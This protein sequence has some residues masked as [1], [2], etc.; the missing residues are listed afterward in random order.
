MKLERLIIGLLI[1]A[2]IWLAFNIVPKYKGVDIRYLTKYEQKI[3]TLLKDTIVFKTKIR[4]F[5]DTLIVYKDSLVY[6]KENNDTVKIIRYQDSII[7]H[8]D[9][10]IKWQDTLIGQM[11]SIVMYQNRLSEKQK[12]RIQ[13]L[14]K[15]VE[16]ETTKKNI[17]KKATATV[18]VIGLTLF[19]IK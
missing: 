10:T 2:L 9:F 15:D 6:A 11:D 4:R 16:K 1:I 8:Q 13:D 3:D 19:L 17:W 18:G 5:K 12:S 14:K 7:V